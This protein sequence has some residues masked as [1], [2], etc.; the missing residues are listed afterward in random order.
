MENN[1]EQLKPV[2]DGRHCKT[3][4]GGYLPEHIVDGYTQLGSG[5]ALVVNIKFC[6]N[7]KAA[8]HTSNYISGFICPV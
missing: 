8:L 3:R 2:I 5:C 7:E 4:R 6:T 1:G